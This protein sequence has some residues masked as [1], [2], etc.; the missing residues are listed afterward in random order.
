M[1]YRKVRK[2]NFRRRRGRKGRSN[3]SF[4][5]GSIAKTALK[6]A[7]WVASV[8][9]VEY[10][11]I[12]F[13]SSSTVASWN[14]TLNTLNTINQG[15][16]VSQRTGDTLKMKTLALRGEFERNT[17]GATSEVCRLIIFIDKDNTITT[18]AQLLN[19]TGSNAV[20]YSQKNEDTKYDTK[21]LYDK[22]F[23]VNSV[24]SPQRF[25][26][27]VIKIPYHAHFV[28]GTSTVGHNA[29]KMA[30][31][32]QNATNGA[33]ITWQSRLSYVDN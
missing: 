2:N 3:H 33:K 27:I 29:L 1:V 23:N 26:D 32:C 17:L 9:N 13:G 15:V 14:G 6:T 10:K 28:A 8:V 19:N 24:S 11:E 18:G 12:Q 5:W 25:F 21:V 22:S 20:V 31:F 16:G 30:Y 4:N 7:K